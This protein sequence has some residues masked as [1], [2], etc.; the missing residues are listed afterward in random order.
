MKA[1]ILKRSID[2]L[3]SLAFAFILTAI[4]L[5]IVAALLTFTS[6]KEDNIPILNTVIMI[7]SI[8]VGSIKLAFKVE[9][10]GWLN[11]GLIGIFYFLLL[12]LINFIFI[13]PF[14]FDIYT[15]GKFFICLIA[16][17]IG[18]MIGVNIK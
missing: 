10:K 16:G 7:L 1:S 15:I 11:G 4:L 18:G 3:K 17:I 2:I 6:L 8:V 14:I 12:L 9:E 5:L 13:R